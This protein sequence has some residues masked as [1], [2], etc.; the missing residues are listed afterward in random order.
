MLEGRYT[1]IEGVDTQLYIF[2]KIHCTVIHL[3]G[4][5]LWNVNDTSVKKPMGDKRVVVKNCGNKEECSD[6]HPHLA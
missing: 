1:V 2:P 6:P 5:V 3:N 4:W